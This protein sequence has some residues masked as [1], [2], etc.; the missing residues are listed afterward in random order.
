MPKYKFG[1]FEAEI[2]PPAVLAL[3]EEITYHPELIALL[4]L[5]ENSNLDSTDRLAVIACTAKQSL[6]ECTVQK[7]FIR[8]VRSCMKF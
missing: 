8:F 2:F 5:P 7:N 1:K 4:E 3:N 6:M